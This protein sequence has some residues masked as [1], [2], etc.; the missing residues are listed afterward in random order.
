MDEGRGTRSGQRRKRQR[1]RRGKSG[2]LEGEFWAEPASPPS[3]PPSCP[4]Y[5]RRMH[6]FCRANNCTPLFADL[7]PFPSSPLRLQMKMGLGFG[8]RMTG[9]GNKCIA[10]TDSVLML[11]Q[12]YKSARLDDIAKIDDAQIPQPRNLWRERISFD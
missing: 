1:A 10:R 3:V 7:S 11:S 9:A 12:S 6:F 5:F 4:S 8:N 2:D